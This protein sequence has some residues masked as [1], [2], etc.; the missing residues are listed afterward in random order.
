VLRV[1]RAADGWVGDVIVTRRL[2]RNP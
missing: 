2:V 1:R